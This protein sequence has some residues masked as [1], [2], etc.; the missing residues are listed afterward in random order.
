M[1]TTGFG[2]LMTLLT[3][4]GPLALIGGPVGIGIAWVGSMVANKTVKWIAIGVGLFILIGVSVGLT[5]RIQ[6]LEQAEAAYKLLNAEHVSLEQ[7][8]GC[9]LRPP[10]EQ[11]LAVCLT[12]RERDAESAK[13]A[14][15]KKM[16]DTAA[17]AANDLAEATAKIADQDQKIESLIESE[18][19]DH[20]GSVPG[21]LTDTWK[22]RR[23]ARGLK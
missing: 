4:A 23:A 19:K 6:H 7:H 8:Y 12:A 1:F 10:Q 3:G 21:V 17:Q 16:A 11:E 14:E 9:Q 22:A 5:V 18:K 2:I 15:L 20:D 13:A